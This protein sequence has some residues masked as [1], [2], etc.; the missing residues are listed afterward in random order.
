MNVGPRV[1]EYCDLSLRTRIRR[2]MKFGRISRNFWKYAALLSVLFVTFD[3]AFWRRSPLA[4]LSDSELTTQILNAFS[5][6]NF[7]NEPPGQ[8]L[9]ED[10][11]EEIGSRPLFFDEGVHCGQAVDLFVGVISKADETEMRAKVRKSWANKAA[12]NASSTRIVFFVGNDKKIDTSEEKRQFNDIAHVDVDESYY[13]LSLKTYAFLKYQEDFCPQAKCV[14]KID[15]DVV[16][17]IAGIEELCRRQNDTPIVTGHCHHEWLPLQRDVSS[18]YYVPRYIYA[19][20][21]YPPYCYGAAYMFSGQQATSRIL[22][23]L[24]Q[25]PFLRS[26]NFRR[27]SE[28]AIFTGLLRTLVS[29]PLQNNLGFSVYQDEY[30]YWC[31]Q[32][33]SPV[34][35]IFHGSK[36]PIE[37]WKRMTTTTN[38]STSLLSYDRWKK[39]RLRGTDLSSAE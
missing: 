34:P 35:L 38:G 39:C 22:A 1:S 6:P 15:S 14:V 33:K 13:N 9:S 2:S 8:F 30:S 28:D 10:W 36:E 21:D 23:S 32:K 17:N 5:M 31:P 18:K 19:H 12:Y 25:T 37:E 26:E 7:K 27:L 4:P 16:A 29:V 3:I 11:T 24:R 20:D